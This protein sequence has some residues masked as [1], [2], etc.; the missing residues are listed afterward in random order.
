MGPS[1]RG[2][3]AHR[4][5]PRR[6]GSSP[7]QTK[8]ANVLTALLAEN[9]QLAEAIDVLR[10]PGCA[11]GGNDAQLAMLLLQVG[12]EKEAIAASHVRS[13][14]GQVRDSG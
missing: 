9:G 12:R 3:N 14:R 8:V 1:G 13:A 7:G 5:R 10:Q 2:E 4:A 6:G 11:Q